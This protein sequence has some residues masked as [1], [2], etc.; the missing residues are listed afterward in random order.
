M[1]PYQYLV[2]LSSQWMI[3]ISNKAKR[4]QGG[5]GRM[6]MMKMAINGNREEKG[7]LKLRIRLTVYDAKKAYVL[8][9]KTTRK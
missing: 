6:G 7:E 4:N 5:E 2:S 3:E 8:M 9:A 1:V